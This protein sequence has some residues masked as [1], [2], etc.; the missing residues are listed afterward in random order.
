MRLKEANWGWFALTFMALLESLKAS[1]AM[2]A[3]PEFTPEI[4][5]TDYGVYRLIDKTERAF[6]AGTT[7]GY[8]SVIHAEHLKSTTDVQLS[9]DVVFGFNYEIV[10]ATAK[11]DWVTVVIDVR[12]P[13]TVNYLGKRSTGFRKLSAAHLKSDG[14]YHNSAYYIFSETYEMVPGEWTITVSYGTDVSVSKR[15]TVR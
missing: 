2:E 10:D 4:F 6:K 11:T 9:R 7:A 1:A 13:D 3:A 15:F 12:H 14:R 8:A 5:I